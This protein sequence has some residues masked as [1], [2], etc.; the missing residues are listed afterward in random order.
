MFS[1]TNR[2]FRFP[3]PAAVLA[4][5]SVAPSPAVASGDAGPATVASEAMKILKTNC[6]SCHNETKQKGG[7]VLTSREAALEGGE[8]G[9]ALTPGDPEQSPV[10]TTLAED[11]DPHMP[12]KKQ[13][14][15]EEIE[16][17]RRWVAEGAPW[18]AAALAGELREVTPAPAPAGWRPALALALSPDGSKLAAGCGGEVVVFNVAGEKPEPVSRASV[19]PDAVQSL[20]WSPDGT[21][22]AAGAFRL[23]TLLNA[24]TLEPAWTTREGLTDRVTAADFLPDGSRVVFADGRVAEAGTL[25]VANAETGEVTAS[26]QAHTDLIFDLA[27]TPD[28][29]LLAS[30][31]GDGLVKL[32]DVASQTEKGRLEGHTTQVLSLAFEADGA[33]LVTGGADQQVKVWDVKSGERV[34]TLG[35]H[36]HGVAAV[37]WNAKGELFA[38]AET[39]ALARYTELQAHTGEQSSRAATEKAFENAATHLS[40]LAVSP[41]GQRVYAGT[42]DG[43][44]VVWDGE[45]KHRDGL[46]LFTAPAPPVRPPSFLRDV[47][48]VLSRAGCMAGACHAKPDGQNGFRLTVFSFDP[49]AD[50]HE[51]VRE[52][53][54]RRVFPS[55]PEESLLLLKA[56]NTVPHEGG[57]RFTY[58]S[59]AAR[60]IREWIAGGMTFR[61]ENEPTLERLTI[62]PAEHVFKPGEELRLRVEAHYSDGSSRDVTTL[63]EYDC[64][65]K[66]VAKVS[67]DGEVS[68]GRVKGQA[69]IITRFM[70]LVADA[71]VTIPPDHLLP[72]SLYAAL[73]VNNFID[74]LSWKHFQ[75]L[76]LYPSEPCDDS[77]FLRRSTLDVIGKP[78]TPEEAREFLDDPSPDKRAKWIE[79]LLEHPRFADHWANKWADLLRPNPDRVGI[80]SVYILDQWLRESFR[81]NKPYDQ[82]VR[83]IV[84]AEGNTHRYGPAVIYRDRREPA[85]L[86]TMF[87]QLFLGVRLDCAKCHHHP[88]EKWGQDDFYRMAAFFGP[89]K[90]RGAG[91]SPPISAGNETFFFAPG[92]KV[93][94]PVTGEVMSPKPPDGPPIE[95]TPDTD[96]RR[97][98]A[99]W[100]AS[101]D[102]PFFARAAANRLWAEFFGKGIVDPVDDF[103]ISNPPSNPELLD[104]L[105]QELVRLKFDM[106]GL[107]R[108]ILNSRLY[109]LSSTPNEHNLTDTRHFS[110]ALR[111]RLPAEVMADAV[112]EITGV[113][114]QFPAMPSGSRA[115]EA[116]TYKIDSPVMDAFGRPNASSD[117]PCERDARPS[118]AQALHL[119]NS[120]RLHAKLSS[121]APE[122]RAHRLASS[123]LSPEEIVTELYL[124][125]YSRRPKEDELRVATA[126][127]EAEG[128][129]RHTA[130]ADVLWALLNSAEFVFNH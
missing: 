45:G 16:T 12:P 130:T 62:T 94:H 70:G 55:A 110:R 20:A 26:W 21:R 90:Q 81:E 59:D 53:R 71:R 56:T 5:A 17:L 72:E 65:D 109:Q 4:L 48:P 115:M 86:T 35:R 42:H 8:N 91:I 126:V 116:W 75:R 96:P 9:A 37:A 103:R 85:E 73:P 107:M 87:S 51:I 104:A 67:E 68:A 106:K 47:L 63:A 60:T 10:V 57:E 11:A 105:G 25:R 74:E 2:S 66:E 52:A 46:E 84:E 89:V 83:E 120:R 31:G 127:F 28:G 80:K 49:E 29:S 113:P 128:A 7:L 27:L 124:A 123:E 36:S 40:S 117:C 33:R 58:D 98:L 77:E 41:D 118:I 112:A 97:A 50:Y 38:A 76:G 13:L 100:M 125:C 122:A 19:A 88:N 78:P 15:G 44:L 114:D 23:L 3:W 18:D 61:E 64:N 34:A 32:W 43:R 1:F 39:G 24:E 92:G 99:D 121:E 22:L 95:E 111:R 30:A 14:P 82:F 101:P 93:K 129:T 69:V 102:N 108:V 79:R 6:V 119:M 54:G